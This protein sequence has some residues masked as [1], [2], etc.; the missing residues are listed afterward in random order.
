MVRNLILIAGAP[1][2]ALMM[3]LGFESQ[4]PGFFFCGLGLSLCILGFTQK[5]TPS[6]LSLGIA[7]ILIRIAA[8]QL[9]PSD[10][11][12]RYLA[13]GQGFWEGQQIW[14]LAPLDYASSNLLEKGLNHPDWPSAYSPPLLFVLGLLGEGVL[15]IHDLRNRMALLELGL[16]S[17]LWL[18]R[19][20]GFALWALN[21]VI[22]FAF[23]GRGHAE[24]LLIWPLILGFEWLRSQKDFKGGLA[25]GLAASIKGLLIPGLFFLIRPLGRGFFPALGILLGG[26]FLLPLAF[27]HGF[28]TLPSG[29]VRFMH[30]LHWFNL[31]PWPYG[32]WI[33]LPLA[34]LLFLGAQDLRQGIFRISLLF[35][36]C[37]PTQHFWYWGPVIAMAASLNLVGTALMG[38]LALLAIPAWFHSDFLPDPLYSRVYWLGILLFLGMGPIRFPKK[39]ASRISV[40]IPVMGEE[41][42]LPA[43][44]EELKAQKADEILIL[45]AGGRYSAQLAEEDVRWLE[46]SRGRGVQ[47]QEGIRQSRYATILILHADSELQKGALDEVR[48]TEGWGV[49]GHRYSQSGL[50][51]FLTERINRLRVRFLGIA[52]GDQGMWFPRSLL[53]GEEPYLNLPI[54]ED[55]ELSLTLQKSGW[56]VVLGAYLIA[57][58]RKWRK[59]RLRSGSKI[60][61][62]LFHWLWLRRFQKKP[63][64]WD[65][66]LSYYSPV[67]KS[68]NS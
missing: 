43:L 44:I 28:W 36:L 48:T 62:L 61:R 7:A 25:L 63:P 12:Y 13:E 26:L 23:A 19:T 67:G 40:L 53:I 64:A 14:T 11:L 6:W 27:G 10:D 9:T 16:V 33:F 18:R 31:F 47:I 35:L 59:N 3:V 22:W 45:E 30:E 20:P 50:F 54:M 2:G 1:L 42:Q 56:P 5:F 41:N 24:I 65:W 46:V 17:F 60:F 34:A 21:P 32:F 51:F 15:G 49:L 58:D 29:F 55:V 4:S 57:S 38:N 8:L 68:R 66:Q 39:R 52:F 37:Q